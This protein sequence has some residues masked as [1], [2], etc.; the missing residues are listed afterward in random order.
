MLKLITNSK[1]NRDRKCVFTCGRN[2]VSKKAVKLNFLPTSVL[3]CSSSK[4]QTN[5]KTENEI[6]DIC[7]NDTAR[8]YLGI[9]WCWL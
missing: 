5:I 8:I 1:G 4:Q 6:N 7:D 3:F 2:L 9:W